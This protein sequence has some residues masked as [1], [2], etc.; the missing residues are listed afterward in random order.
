MIRNK[1]YLSTGII[2]RSTFELANG[3]VNSRS[4]RHVRT[5]RVY[6]FSGLLFCPDCGSRMGGINTYGYTYY[7]CARHADG[8]CRRK[9]VRETDVEQFLLARLLPA[10][11]GINLTIKQKQKKSVNLS[12][13]KKKQD[14]LTDLYMDD[15]ISKEKYAEDFKALQSQIEEAEREPKPIDKKEI[16]T[17]LQAY[18]GLSP[19]AKKAF[20]SNLVTRIVPT[21]TGYDFTLFYT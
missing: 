20:W 11:D 19:A 10:V 7:R 14:K 21:E 5:D 6:L 17:V 15:L 8:L 12:D 16:K 1:T 3:I 13:L 2:D 18:D 4:Q 9:N